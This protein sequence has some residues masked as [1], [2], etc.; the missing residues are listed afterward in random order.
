MLNNA[1]VRVL[2]QLFGFYE[3]F[4]TRFPMLSAWLIVAP[5]MVGFVWLVLSYPILAVLGVIVWAA[6]LRYTKAI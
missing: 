2:Q 4:R 5:I 3:M 1:I 6:E